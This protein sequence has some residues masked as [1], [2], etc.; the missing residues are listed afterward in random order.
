[1]PVQLELIF[2]ELYS[3]FVQ[4]QAAAHDVCLSD[5]VKKLAKK[6]DSQSKP[7]NCAS[8]RCCVTGDE[9]MKFRFYPVIVIVLL[10]GIAAV[11]VTALRPTSNDDETVLPNNMKAV[12]VSE[13]SHHVEGIPVIVR[14]Y[15]VTDGKIMR[16]IESFTDD[17]AARRVILRVFVPADVTRYDPKLG[18]MVTKRQIALEPHILFDEAV[19]DD[20]TA[21]QTYLASHSLSEVPIDARP[22]N[23]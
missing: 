8:K 20:W 18:R 19:R 16:R 5:S 23:Q 2:H 11:S 3:R 4:N 15:H 17:W 6:K 21:L 9:G 22:L 14:D 7:Q 12:L 1:M 13:F 10:L